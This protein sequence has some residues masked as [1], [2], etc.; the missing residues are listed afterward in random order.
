[1]ERRLHVEENLSCLL[2]SLASLIYGSV[3]MLAE[4]GHAIVPVVSSL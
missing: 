1:M 4:S 2:V 3:F